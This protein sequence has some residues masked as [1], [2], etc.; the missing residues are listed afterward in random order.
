MLGGISR[1]AAAI[2]PTLRRFPP[3]GRSLRNTTTNS[4][5]VAGGRDASTVES[6][7][8][9]SECPRGLPLCP[10]RSSCQ[11]RH[12][13]MVMRHGSNSLWPSSLWRCSMACEAP[14]EHLLGNSAPC[15]SAPGCCPRNSRGRQALGQTPWINMTWASVEDPARVAG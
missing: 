15:S 11:L 2:L 14:R 3:R 6:V 1:F 13:G 7:L 12:H 8:Q 10:Q 5:Q 4:R 9:S